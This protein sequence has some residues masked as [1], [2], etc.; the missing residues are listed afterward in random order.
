MNNEKDTIK[1]RSN[2]R[3]TKNRLSFSV[4]FEIDDNNNIIANVSFSLHLHKITNKLKLNLVKLKGG[5][6]DACN[7]GR[8]S[9]GDSGPL[10]LTKLGILLRFTIFCPF[11]W[12]FSPVALFVSRL[13]WVR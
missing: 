5:T 8:R 13:P 12:R 7:G 4:A 11:S 1:L 2:K 3:R 6:K 9:S 10:A